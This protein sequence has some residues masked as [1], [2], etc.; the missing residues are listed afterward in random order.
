MKA[1]CTI[2]CPA[3]VNAQG[4]VAL[5]AKGRFKEA[6]ELIRR[7]LPLPSVCGRV[8]THPCEAMCKRQELDEPIAIKDLKRFVT[9]Q[10]SFTPESLP[11]TKSQKVTV[12]GSGPAGLSTAWS[13][14]K[15]GYPVTVFEALPVAGGMLAVGLPEY[16][17][18]KAILQRDL[19]FLKALG[20]EIRTDS[21]IGN[22][23]KLY[24]LKDQGYEA[25]F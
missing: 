12:I 14:A 25:I 8:C 18:P 16:R 3:G 19:D 10:V 2:A 21:P 9:D 20:I 6:R 13:L 22:S 5:I 4:Y 7:D 23:L 24:D 15:R 17:L 1:P 11:I